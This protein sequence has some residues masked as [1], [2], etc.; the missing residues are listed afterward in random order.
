MVRHALWSSAPASCPASSHTS[1]LLPLNAIDRLR[2]KRCAVNAGRHIIWLTGNEEIVEK[3]EQIFKGRPSVRVLIPAVQHFLVNFIRT[4]LRTCHP[5]AL[6]QVTKNIMILYS[7][8]KIV[9]NCIRPESIVRRGRALS[10]PI[11]N[12]AKNFNFSK[13]LW[14][15]Y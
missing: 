8:A 4:I 3:G 1:T 13:F 11:E 12:F 5:F 7:C 15:I 2:I 10:P 6:V 14:W 9:E